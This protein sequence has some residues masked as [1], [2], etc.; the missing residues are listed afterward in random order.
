MRVLFVFLLA[1]TALPAWAET[2]RYKFVPQGSEVAFFYEFSGNQTRGRMPVKAADLSLDFDDVRKSRVS[3]RLDPSRARAGFAFATEA[4][5][6][7]SVLDTA[8]YPEIRFRTTAFRQTPDGARVTGELTVRG[9]TR[10]V[11]L[12]GRLFRAPGAAEGDNRRLTVRLTGSL[13]RSAFGAVGFPKLVGDR[14]T[15]DITAALQQI[16]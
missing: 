14:I 10:P 16:P 3:V 1:F 11:T 6:G 15:L 7:E 5:K 2:V 13:S 8:R 9:V 12:N 4:M